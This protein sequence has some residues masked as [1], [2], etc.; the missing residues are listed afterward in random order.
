M[1]EKSLGGGDL[2]RFLEAGASAG[3]EDPARPSAPVKA[4]C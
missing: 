1:G 2:R 3:K 4:A